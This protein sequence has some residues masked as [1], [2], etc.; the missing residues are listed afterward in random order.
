LEVVEIGLPPAAPLPPQERHSLVDATVAAALLPPRP[1]TGHKGIFGHLLVVG[2]SRG[3]SGALAL[4]ALGGLRSGAGL[5]TAAGPASVQ[6]VLAQQLLEAMSAPLPEAG[7]ELSRQVLPELER[8]WAT[9]SALVLGPGL[10][11]GEES[12]N[13]ARQLL[14]DCPL[15]LVLDAD[16]LNALA[17][18]PELLRERAGRATILTPHPGEMA[19]LCACSIAQVEADRVGIARS[20]ARRHQVVLVLKGARSLI[21]TPEGEIFV[22]GSGNPG[23]ANGGTGDVLAGLL[24]GLL[25]QGLPAT[26]AAVLGVYLHGLAAERLSRQQGEAGL[27]AS[28]LAR[29][30]PAARHELFQQGAFH[31]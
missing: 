8:L 20:F 3:K 7:G 10:G 15:P 19:R 21:A 28:D 23:L 12:R 31:A 9:K 30:L 13:L 27:T 1:A 16:G 17:M 11:E 25:A 29:E 18:D 26:D 2:G 14:V 4:A 24:G 22:N 6:P 5:V